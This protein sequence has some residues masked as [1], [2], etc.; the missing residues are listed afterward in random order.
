MTALRL[1]ADDLTGALD[2][3]AELVGITGPVHAYWHGALPAALPA[4][5]ALDSGT[6]E[7]AEATA[8]ATVIGLTAASRG[9]GDRLQEG[10]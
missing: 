5:A 1:L 6:R 7:L 8:T 9:G 4:N 3:A 2:T 10:R